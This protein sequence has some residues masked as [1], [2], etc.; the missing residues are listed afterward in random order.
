MMHDSILA[1]KILDNSGMN[2]MEKVN[3]LTAMRMDEDGNDA[4]TA[5]KEAMSKT[6][7][8]LSA[9]EQEEIRKTYIR[10]DYR[11]DGA[12]DDNQRGGRKDYWRD[13][14]QYDNQRGERKYEEGRG[15]VYD[16]R[17]E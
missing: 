10:E 9:N 17:Y 6:K 3:V 1:I 14:S 12:I 2:A 15:K 5:M 8:V 11:R 16:N 7:G 4:Y 13:G